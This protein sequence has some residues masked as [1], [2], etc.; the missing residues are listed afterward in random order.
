MHGG[1]L[2]YLVEY[3][4]ILQK[5]VHKVSVCFNFRI[6]YP[7]FYFSL[8]KQSL[9]VTVII[10][11]LVTDSMSDFVRGRHGRRHGRRGRGRLGRNFRGRNFRGRQGRQFEEN[12]LSGGG[13]AE[14]GGIDF[15]GCEAQP[16]GMCCVFKESSVK[17]I[18]KDPILECTHK[19]VEKCHYTYVTEFIPSQEE[20]CDENFEKKCQIT[21]KK[22]ATTETVKKCYTPLEKVCGGG[23]SLSDP[24]LPTYGNAPPTS[25]LPNGGNGGR[26]NGGVNGGGHNRGNGNGGGRNRGNGNG[27][28]EECK[29]FYESSCTTKY[30]EKQPGKFVGD[31]RCEKLPI[32]LCGQGCSV[33]EGEEECHDKDVT[34]V[35]DV[36]EEVCDL[37][38]I[39]LCKTVTRLTPQL[40]PTH[41][42]TRIPQ[43]VC[44]LKFSAPEEIDKPLMT[45]WCIDPNAEVIPD[46]TYDDTTS[47]PV[48]TT[49]SSQPQPEY[50]GPPPPPPPPPRVT[51]EPPTLY[52]APASAARDFATQGFG[53]FATPDL[54]QDFSA[55]NYQNSFAPPAPVASAYNTPSDSGYGAPTAGYGGPTPSPNNGGYGAPTN[56]FDDSLPTYGNDLPSYGNGGGG[57]SLPSY[58][59]GYSKRQADIS[60]R[61]H[62]TSAVVSYARQHNSYGSPTTA[63]RQQQP[64]IVYA[65][66]NY[67]FNV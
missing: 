57:D 15:S 35:I 43:E 55:S 61:Q 33:M 4:I 59:A 44:Q 36:P 32:K 66:P 23:D 5:K 8:Q 20:V 48:I 30:I 25:Y 12:A 64:V 46:E 41:E 11:A 29:T 56:G 24:S 39:K 51:T 7:F 34:S 3:E 17:S 26:G 54:P 18:K 53:S 28:E 45:K 52:G 62:E 49:Q 42:C 58:G 2:G 67:S 38:P 31:T 19:E 50:G 10:M 22:M 1:N 37:N 16:D 21:F 9:I 13:V 60:A 47:P 63:P 40:K 14:G 27:G 65:Q 6:F